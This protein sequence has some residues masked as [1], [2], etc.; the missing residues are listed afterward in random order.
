M[1]PLCIRTKHELQ[2][3][4]NHNG[5]DTSTYGDT[6]VQSIAVSMCSGFERTVFLVHPEEAPV[7]SG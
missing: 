6:N 5:N 2:I 4:I 7:S 1:T 3:N